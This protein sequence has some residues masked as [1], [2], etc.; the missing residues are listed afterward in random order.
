[1]PATHT[2]RSA[3]AARTD[4]YWITSNRNPSRPGA[5]PSAAATAAAIS[6][7][8]RA[9]DD[10]VSDGLCGPHIKPIKVIDPQHQAS[11]PALVV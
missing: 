9:A 1:L 10:K 4:N 11:F 3:R 5:N 8:T 2:D 6:A 7:A